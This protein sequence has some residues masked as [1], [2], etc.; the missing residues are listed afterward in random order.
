[1]DETGAGTPGAA[2]ATAAPAN[3]SLPLLAFIFLVA[4]LPLLATPVLPFIDFYNHLAR[5]HVLATIADDSVLAANYRAAW[6]VLPNIG[7][8]VIVTALLRLLPQAMIAHA[9]AI[10]IFAVQFGGVL[11]FNR[12]LTGRTHWLTAVLVVPLLYSFILNWGFANFL[13]GL[14]LLFWGAGW[15]LAMRHRLIVA[16]PVAIVIAA[17]IFL[18]HGLAFGLYGLTLGALEIGLWW[19]ARPRRSARLLLAM[20]PLAAQAVLPVLLFRMAETSAVANGLTNADESAVRLARSGQ[21][22]SRLWS[23]AEYRLVTIARVAEGPS[24]AFDALTLAATLAILV[25]LLRQRA[26]ALPRASWPVLALGG[27]LVIIMPPALF[28]VGYCADRMPL[29]LALL[30]VGALAVRRPPPPALAGALVLLVAVRLAGIAW[31]WQGYRRDDADFTTVAAALPAGA[32]VESL[33]THTERL[34][35]VRRCQMY[36][37]RLIAEHHGIGRLFANASQQPL[38]LAGP[39]A[40]AVAASGRPS[41]ADRQKPGYFAGV[42]TAAARAGF[43]WLLLCDGA[44]IALPKGS[45]VAAQAGRFTLIHLPERR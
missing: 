19:Q 18:V 2:A 21:L 17:G 24:L 6:A 23:L 41:F 45:R 28:G 10:L 42:V 37:P 1:M 11:V 43:P 30:A 26:L 25:L 14:G 33:F 38:Q 5:Y 13:L 32:M 44:G 40:A 31:D 35:P 9:T 3:A 29:F 4:L 39:L 8:D 36:G 7:L 12:A 27:L 20:L 15:W 22:A 16:L 34:D